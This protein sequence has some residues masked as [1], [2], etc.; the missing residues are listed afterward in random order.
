MERLSVKF[1]KTGNEV[2]VLLERRITYITGLSGAGKTTFLTL[3][4][5]GDVLR[6]TTSTSLPIQ[7]VGYNGL[8]TF[9]GS[10]NSIIMLDDYASLQETNILSLIMTYAVKNNLWVVILGREN[11]EED[12][13]IPAIAFSSIYIMSQSGDEFT[14]KK[15]FLSNKCFISNIH[16]DLILVEDSKSGYDFVKRLNNTSAIVEPLHGAQ[17]LVKRI[18]EEKRLGI[19]S[20]SIFVFIDMASSGIEILKLAKLLRM[21]AYRG[22][23]VTVMT[24]YECFEELLLR[25]NML[26]GSVD[27]SSLEQTD[28]NNY[29]SWEN[30]YEDVLNKVTEGKLFRAYHGS[31]TRCYVEKC[32]YLKN[33]LQGDKCEFHYMHRKEEKDKLDKF[34]FLLEGTKYERLLDFH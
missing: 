1:N 3:L 8:G 11:F 16:Y 6:V 2:E 27:L 32:C 31:M 29:V 19:S 23:N 7:V 18:V 14:A 5:S 20:I 4:T 28:A 22:F 9:A 10:S 13:G 12:A 15:L 17:N 21:K 24:D 33:E 30:F 34:K 25:T 26:N